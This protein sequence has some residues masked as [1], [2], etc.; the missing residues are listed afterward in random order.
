MNR[1]Y[2]NISYAESPFG[3]LSEFM[4]KS[5]GWMFAGLLVTFGVGIGAVASGLIFPI[6]NSGLFI[7]TSIAE[8]VMVFVLSARVQKLQPSTATALFFGYA[9]LNGI[10]LSS[11]FLVYDY[12]TLILAF[13][14]GAVY[15]GV[16][17]V[18]GN[19]TDRDLTG[20][21]PKLMGGLVAL[22]VCALVGSLLSMFGLNFG[23]A[24]LLLCAVGLLIFMGLTA[25]DTQ[26]L[27]Y[28]YSYF[29]GDAAML[30]K[31]SIIGALNLYLDFIN[32]FLYIV[33]MLGRRNND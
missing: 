24:D 9:V 10:N 15:F 3:T 21:G 2:S 1:N 5:F 28:Y 8:L 12:G 14:V 23:I 30:H 6:I 19:V 29:G 4:S 26:M 11:I 31:A 32:I 18:Y 20:W 27:K 17:A 22:I 7:F 33:R 13:L 16:M 25:Y